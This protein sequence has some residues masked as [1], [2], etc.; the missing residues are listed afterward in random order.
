MT[1]GTLT[2]AVVFVWMLNILMV[3]SQLAIDDMTANTGLRFL[4]CSGTII[5][6]YSTDADCSA[7]SGT[8]VKN[9][10]SELPGGATAISGVF[11]VDWIT[12]ASSWIGKQI[13][14]FTQVANAPKNMLQSIPV[15]QEERF[16]TFASLIGI[17]WWALSFL[18]IVA[19]IFG[20]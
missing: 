2:T 14:T 1:S 20:R 12:S 6:T 5:S 17:M 15:F 7:L 13:D 3:F 4:N 11:I 9:L 8:T 10:S 18:L 16:A 19:F